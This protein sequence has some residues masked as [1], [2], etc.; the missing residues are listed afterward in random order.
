MLNKVM[1]IGNIGQDPEVTQVPNGS[2]VAKMT[3][4]TNR[5]WTTADGEKREEVTWHNLEAWS[6]LADIA[7]QYLHKGSKVYVEGR[8][9]VDQWEDRETGAK[10]SRTKVVCERITFLGDRGGNSQGSQ[11]QPGP[12]DENIPF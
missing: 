4:A 12:A 10:R 8:L 1:L 2:S 11:G 9:K 6:K 7:S 3:L 5:K